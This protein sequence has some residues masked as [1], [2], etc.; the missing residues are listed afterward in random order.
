MN[1][2]VETLHL[3]LEDVG[4]RSWWA[5]VLTTLGSQHGSATMRFVGRVDGERRYASPTFAM[6]RTVGT[7]PPQ[8]AWAP[9]MT[10]CLD[11]LR[12][13]LRFDGWVPVARGSEPWDETFERRD[14]R[15]S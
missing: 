10:Q 15:G 1:A 7:V 9:E 11:E 8:E 3:E 12:G 13:E 6:P 4:G 2:D 5:G 14:G